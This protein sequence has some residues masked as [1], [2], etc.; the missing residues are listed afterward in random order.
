MA[1]APIPVPPAGL[2]LGAI[3]GT[4]NVLAWRHAADH[5]EPA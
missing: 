5:L 2:A 3:V 4:G 1:W